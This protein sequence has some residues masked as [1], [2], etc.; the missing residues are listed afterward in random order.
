LETLDDEQYGLARFIAV[1]VA[2]NYHVH[3]RLCDEEVQQRYLR[4]SNDFNLLQSK[5]AAHL[6][7]YPSLLHSHIALCKFLVSALETRFLS[8]L[9]TDLVLETHWEGMQGM[10]LGSGSFL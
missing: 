6:T 9:Y 8:Y 1:A 3:G 7:Q 4:E 2:K 10:H 5:E